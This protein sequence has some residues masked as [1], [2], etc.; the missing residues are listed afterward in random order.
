M[1]NILRNSI[2][3]FEYNQLSIVQSIISQSQR[4]LIWGMDILPKL[5]FSNT[6]NQNEINTRNDF[7]CSLK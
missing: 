4:I 5:M 6:L 1:F 7:V 3:E 2:K